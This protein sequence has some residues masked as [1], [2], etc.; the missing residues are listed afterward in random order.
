MAHK[1]LRRPVITLA[2]VIA[3]LL[4]L[5]VTWGLGGCSSPQVS[6]AA[7]PCLA[8]APHFPQRLRTAD[9]S[10]TKSEGYVRNNVYEAA[11]PDQAS[12]SFQSPTQ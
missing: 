3:T 4:L 7:G 10:E 2:H 8:L 5:V 1:R 12:P 6:A 9:T 11:C